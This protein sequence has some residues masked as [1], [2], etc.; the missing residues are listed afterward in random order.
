MKI[1]KPVTDQEVELRADASI[2]STTDLKG[3]ITYVN[4]E[5]LD[6]SGFSSEELVGKNHN[7]I[8]HPDMPPTAFQDLWDTIEDGK[9]WMGMVKNRCKNG[10]YYWV[11]AYVMPIQQNGQTVEY[12]SVRFKPKQNWIKRAES[13]YQKIQEG[14]KIKP[15]LA[16]KLGFR[17][18]LILGNLAALIPTMLVTLVEPLTPFV[19]AGLISTGILSILINTLLLKPFQMMVTQANEIFDNQLMAQIYT[20]RDDEFGQIQLALKMQHSQ[21]NA[22]VGRLEDTTRILSGVAEVTA[23]TSNQAR[24]GV[25]TQHEQIMQVST[26]M[27]EM[28]ATVQE[29][30][31]NAAK[32]SEST[33]IGL[34]ETSAGTQ[35]VDSTIS[36]INLLASEV[37]QAADVIHRLSDYTTNIGN[38]L[39]VIK[40]IAE[41]TNL[42]ALNAA[43]EAA[44]AGEEGRGFAVVA[45][46]VRTLAARTTESAREIEE[47]IK[48]LQ[49]GSDE[50][51]SVMKKSKEKAEENVKQASEAG[52]ALQTI[53]GAINN[54][55]DMNHQ[56]ATASEEQSAVADEINRNIVNI[57]EVAEITSQ[58]ARQSV[59]ATSDMIASIQRLNS[60]VT[61]FRK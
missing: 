15:S 14:R 54:I 24:K 52:Q 40:G 6:I 35:V 17:N 3:A 31:E 59:E 50:A 34:T 8:R 56:I 10:D 26:A 20:G 7:V 5:F 1:N 13:I 48:L 2:L 46:E 38:V 29:I 41:Q 60:L 44:R 37:Q 47:M 58:G 45:D 21:I 43:I 18:K 55:T 25:D 11:N 49:G 27:T 32:A 53:G 19:A 39:G 57:S 28:A 16:S 23:G 33:K 12:Q 22:I 61:Q 4:P 9:P 51:V 36:A 42:L 30:A